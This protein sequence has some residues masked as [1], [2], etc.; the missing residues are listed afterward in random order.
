MAVHPE[1]AWIRNDVAGAS[2]GFSLEEA[3]D[4]AFELL[5]AASI[6]DGAE[7]LTGALQRINDETLASVLSRTQLTCAL[8]HICLVSV[9]GLTDFTGKSVEDLLPILRAAVTNA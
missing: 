8:V 4:R 9:G 2:P 1:R 6:D 7:L 5:G 3:L